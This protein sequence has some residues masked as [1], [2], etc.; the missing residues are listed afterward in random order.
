MNSRKEQLAAFNRLLDIMDELREKCPW[1]KKQT[2][3][4]LRHLTIE[5]TYELADA[6]LDNDLQEIKKELGDVLLHI[7]FYAKIGSEKKAFDIGDVANS[8]SDKLISRHPHIY[9]DVKVKN[10]E[11]V[12]RNWEQLKLKEG[13]KSVLEGVPKSL[14]A[15][16]KASRIQEKV[17]GV[18]FDWEKPEQVWEKVQEELE[19]LNE[20]I[21]KGNKEN[22][23]KE[24]GDVLFSMINY[25]RF[26]DVNPENALEKTNKKFINR[27]QFLEKI[28]KKEGKNISEMTFAEM[29]V[30][31]EKSKEFFN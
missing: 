3:E 22:T 10:E 25:A 2:L 5:E 8:I 27:F 18:G 7:V 26:I 16:V 4:S 21:K 31:W 13:K 29:D 17:A 20:E 28:A 6:I 24:F 15:V 19:E 30:Y 14:P 1:D 12:K 23:E 9:G 11:D